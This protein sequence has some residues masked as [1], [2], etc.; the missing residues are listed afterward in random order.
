METVIVGFTGGGRWIKN[1]THFPN[2]LIEM[3]IDQAC[4]EIAKHFKCTAEDA[5]ESLLKHKFASS[6][7]RHWHLKG[8]QVQ[9]DMASDCW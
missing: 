7:N 5:R 6:Q 1:T 4:Q 3:P 2:G 9:G 8:G